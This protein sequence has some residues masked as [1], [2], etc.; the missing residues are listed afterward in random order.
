MLYKIENT[1]VFDFEITDEDMTE[2]NLMKYC[3]GS[4][5]HPDKVDF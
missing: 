3:G 5:L 4:E 2:I 1:N